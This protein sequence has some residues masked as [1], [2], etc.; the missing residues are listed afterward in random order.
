ML[1]V[2]KKAPYMEVAHLDNR[3][4]LSAAARMQPLT[5]LLCHDFL[6]S[7]TIRFGVRN[8]DRHQTASNKYADRQL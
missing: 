1:L 5:F 3:I 7:A 2:S 6:S 8:S 4:A